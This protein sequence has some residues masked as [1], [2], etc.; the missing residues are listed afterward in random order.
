MEEDGSVKEGGRLKSEEK[1]AD[2]FA[3]SNSVITLVYMT[4][5]RHAG[6]DEG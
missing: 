3:H 5:Y 2:T 4:M 6:K 1:D